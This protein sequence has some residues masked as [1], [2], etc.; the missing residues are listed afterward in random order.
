MSHRIRNIYAGAQHGD[1][2]TASL[3][4]RAVRRGVDPLRHSTDHTGAGASESSCEPPRNALAVRAHL[5]GADDGHARQIK[6]LSI[7]EGP[8]LLGWVPDVEKRVREVGCR[9]V[10]A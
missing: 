3:D 5:S 8:Q 1:S 2:A 4:S 9:A 6:G 7:S 10:P